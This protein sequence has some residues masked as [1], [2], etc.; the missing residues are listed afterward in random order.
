MRTFRIPKVHPDEIAKECLE[1]LDSLTDLNK[2]TSLLAV[3]D[4]RRTVVASRPRT[5]APRGDQKTNE[6]DWVP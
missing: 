3:S 5:F 1:T 6:P 2:I 4:H